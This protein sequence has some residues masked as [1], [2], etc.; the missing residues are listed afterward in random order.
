MKT[1]ILFSVQSTTRLSIQSL[2]NLNQ[3]D[4]IYGTITHT[5]ELYILAATPDILHIRI[6]KDLLNPVY[7]NTCSAVSSDYLPIHIGK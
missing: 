7:L 1:T 5:T 2:I 3:S 6:R 4:L